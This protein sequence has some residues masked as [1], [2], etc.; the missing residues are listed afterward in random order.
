MKGRIKSDLILK[1][2]MNVSKRIFLKGRS[3]DGSLTGPWITAKGKALSA[4]TNVIGESN[5]QA[6]EGC[7]GA[8]NSFYLLEILNEQDNTIEIKNY[9][10]NAKKKINN[11]QGHIESDL[12]YPTLRGREIKRWSAIPE[13][14]FLFV[15]NPIE[16]NK[17]MPLIDLKNIQRLLN[18]FLLLK[19][20]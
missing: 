11:F 15:Q 9:T 13:I 4:I 17:G 14:A 10:K 8:L 6:R 19:M 20:I 7:S 16:P 1:D 3:I 18:T 12:V 2:V 5:Y